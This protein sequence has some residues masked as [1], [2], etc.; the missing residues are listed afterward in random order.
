MTINFPNSPSLGQLYTFGETTWQWSGEYW[1]VYS[2]QTGY[3][4]SVSSAGGGIPVIESVTSNALT[5][6]SFS[7][8]NLT[9]TDNNGLLNFYVPLNG[10]GGGQ[11]YYFNISKTQTPYRE[12][13]T[14]AT[15]GSEQTI[16]SGTSSGTTVTL[17]QFLTPSGFPGVSIIPGGVWTFFLHAFKQ[18]ASAS[19]TIYCDVYK[20]TTGGTETLLLT[21]DPVPITANSPTP[22]MFVS[23]AY[24]SG[25]TLNTTDRLLVNVRA[26]NTGTGTTNVT[27]VSEG[28]QHYSYMSSPL[29]LRTTD[30]YVD[31]FTYTPSANTITIGQTENFPPQT[32][33][34][35]SFSGLSITSGLT[36]NTISA[37]T[38]QNV[39]AV[40]GGSYSNGIITLSGTGNVNGA[41]ITGFS[42]ST[43]S[44]FTG[45]TVSGATQFTGGLSAN[46]ISATTYQ[47]LPIATTGV[48]GVLTSSN[49]IDLVNKENI[50][51][52]D[53]FP[54][55]AIT[56]GTS[57]TRSLIK[58][59]LIPAN[60]FQRGDFMEIWAIGSKVNTNTTYFI[61]ID[62]NTGNTLTGAIQLGRA[63]SNVA[64]VLYMPIQRIA[65]F[66]TSTN[67]KLGPTG[68][69]Y[70]TETSV[71]A[72]QSNITFN[73]AVNN[74]ILVS[75]YPTTGGGADIMNIERVLVRKAL[76]KI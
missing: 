10:G 45:G 76:G 54:G 5:L 42:T 24:Y 43:G 27:F 31:S 59:Y 22:L 70:V 35:N 63:F 19:F 18:N 6:K 47:N 21:T 34:I 46:T 52:A 49:F 17:G 7:G 2:A 12:L 30:I 26:T 74:Y 40:T 68:S 51:V 61:Q 75:I 14:S 20:R 58:S 41:Q 53:A 29:L 33:T 38:Y 25:T 23:D 57:L 13:A 55:T 65:S 3:I 36:V 16:T 72:A 71:A 8:T 64:S 50:I 48:T 32:V 67:L 44:A 73:T 11:L 62:V 37:T 28:T 4:T 56:G 60:T 66:T 9:I 1:N 69:N 39:N 15:T